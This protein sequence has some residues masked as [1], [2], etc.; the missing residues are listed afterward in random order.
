MEEF[1]L[2][3]TLITS[4]SS[5][6]YKSQEIDNT[7]LKPVHGCDSVTLLYMYYIKVTNVVVSL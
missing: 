3:K 2:K 4:C 6:L 1:V 7:S 5:T